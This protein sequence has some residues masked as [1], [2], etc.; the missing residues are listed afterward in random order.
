MKTYVMSALLCCL[1]FISLAG[2]PALYGSI[3][4]TPIEHATFVMQTKQLTVFV[5]PVGDAERFR[6]FGRPD[7][8]LI[9]DIHYDHMELDLV[10]KLA[11][12]ETNILAPKAVIKQLGQGKAIN[13]GETLRMKN[14][15]VEAVAMY[16]LTESR[17]KYHPKGRG[18]GYVVTLSDKRIYISGDTEDVPEMRALENIDIAIVCMNLPYTMTPQQA[19]SAVIEMQPKIAIPYHY[20]GTEGLSDINAFSQLVSA[21]NIRVDLLQ[22]Y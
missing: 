19:A 1:S 13:N 15:V 14:M 5:D 12:V 4:I 7:V 21:K 11:G 17:L 16:N 2:E 20:R 3:R 22:W 10:K 9:T 8:I 18:N 6:Q